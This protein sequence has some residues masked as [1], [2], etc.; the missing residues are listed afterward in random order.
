MDKLIFEKEERRYIYDS[1]KEAEAHIWRMS[2]KG[3]KAGKPYKNAG[4]CY[5]VKYTR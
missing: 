2:H 3:W 1:E 5:T 4:G